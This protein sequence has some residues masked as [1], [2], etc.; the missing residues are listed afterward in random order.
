MNTYKISKEARAGYLNL[1]EMYHSTISGYKITKRIDGKGFYFSHKGKEYSVYAEVGRSHS[2][3]FYIPYSYKEKPFSAGKATTDYYAA[4]FPEEK[5]LCIGNPKRIRLFI[6]TSNS[7]IKKGT[8]KI[9]V[10][11]VGVKRKDLDSMFVKIEDLSD[12]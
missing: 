5:L 2:T 11:W 7:L 3:F 10:E 4:I 12:D 8:D 1:I 9:G 6:A